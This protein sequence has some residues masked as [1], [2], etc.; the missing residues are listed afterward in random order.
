VIGAVGVLVMAVIAAAGEPAAAPSD[1]VYSATPLRALSQEIRCGW[2]NTG[3]VP[4]SLSIENDGESDDRLVSAST[5]VARCVRI[6]SARFASGRPDS[7]HVSGGLVIPPGAAVTFEAGSAHLILLGLRQNLVQGETF[8]LTL[9]F[10]G[11]GEAPV[12]ARVRRR[13]DAAGTLPLPPVS[14]GD[15]TVARVSAPPAAMVHRSFSDNVVTTTSVPVAGS[16][17]PLFP[18]GQPLGR[19]AG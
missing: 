12:V 16:C 5:P 15:L 8:P 3:G 14:V 18:S 10:D 4:V 13:V 9:Y 7:D 1:F 11:A 2:E 6:E 17:P 19:A